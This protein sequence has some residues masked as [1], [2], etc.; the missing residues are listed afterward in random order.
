MARDTQRAKVYAWE[1]IAFPGFLTTNKLTPRETRELIARVYA[2]VAAA[3]GHA[4]DP[5]IKFTKRAGSACASWRQLNF[6]P[7]NITLALALH[8]IAHS[9]TYDS[10]SLHFALR[11]LSVAPSELS[12]FQSHA[13]ERFCDQGHGPRYVACYIAL[14]ERYAGHD[15]DKARQTAALFR[16]EAWGPWRAV[17]TSMSG[18]GRPRTHMQRRRETKIGRVNVSVAALAYWRSLLSNQPA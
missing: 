5:V 6:T 10:L 4:P 12:P 16:Y 9:L 18:D 1:R 17:S 7:R 3:G 11:Q 15:P 2:D 8:E 14:M 13:L